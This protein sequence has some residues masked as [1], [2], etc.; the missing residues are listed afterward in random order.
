MKKKQQQVKTSRTLS[1][2]LLGLAVATL[3]LSIFQWAEL[4]AL[5]RGVKPTCAINS[6]L[7]CETVWNSELATAIHRLIGLPVAG[8]GVVWSLAA[9]VVTAL[10][11]ARL[12]K[13]QDAETGPWVF[14]A[15]VL[16]LIGIA[17]IVV[18]GIESFRTGAVCLTC[19]GTY[20]LT[21]TF[22]IVAFAVSDR[23]FKPLPHDL[24]EGLKWGALAL[25]GAYTLSLLV[26]LS[27][28]TG[29]LTGAELVARAESPEV[30]AAGT[31]AEKKLQAYLAGLPQE[32]KQALSDLIE[33]YRQ[34]PVRGKP[35]PTRVR[36]GPAD[37]PLKM[38]EFTD[39]RCGH[40]RNLSET[41]KVLKKVA[42]PGSLS[43]E[44]RYF[45]L[46]SAC[47]PK[48]QGTD[49]TGVR[50]VGAKAQICLEQ[51]PD[52]WELRE[53]LF[54]QQSSL[55]TP[56][57]VLEIASSGSVSRQQLEACIASPETNAK[58]QEDIAYGEEQ[59]LHGTPL[60]LLNGKEGSPIGA[61]LY[62]MVLTE[63]DANSPA[64]ASLPKPRPMAPHD[65]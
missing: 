52:F 26:G 15:R 63:G 13:G 51:A 31:D 37:A 35:R 12:R 9:L 40:C 43:I 64:F 19:L 2:V 50:C 45:P 21:G 22:A 27:F 8:L 16:G 49:G 10:L 46:D 34:T 48:M 44:P 38:V 47:N 53:K 11:F 23:P 65:H 41:L 36:Y 62:A 61:F 29:K 5:R 17:A 25:F 57:R 24:R 32:Q 55:T 18:F 4:V 6:T 42:P 54:E 20:A 28:P 3:G 56:E 33:Q 30:L 1:A 58:L 39:I 59:D 14:A 7:N 60:V